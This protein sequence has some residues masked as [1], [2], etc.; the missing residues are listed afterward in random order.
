MIDRKEEDQGLASQKPD[1]IEPRG[2]LPTNDRCETCGG[3]GRIHVVE[4][5]CSQAHDEDCPTCVGRLVNG[6]RMFSVIPR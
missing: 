5:A 6:V 4:G 1:P 3:S 2:A